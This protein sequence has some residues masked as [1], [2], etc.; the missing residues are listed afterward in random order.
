MSSLKRPLP[1]QL[2]TPEE[3]A[4]V[5][6]RPALESPDQPEQQP[7]SMAPLPPPQ[8]NLEKAL[9]APLRHGV[10]ATI[11]PVLYP[12]YGPHDFFSDLHSYSDEEAVQRKAQI[13]QI[14]HRF[15]PP[16]QPLI[17]NESPANDGGIAVPFIFPP[18]PL[19]RPDFYLNDT[20]LRP[21]PNQTTASVSPP[22]PYA[23]QSA[24]NKRLGMEH[25]TIWPVIPPLPFPPPNYM[26]YPLIAHKAPLTPGEVFEEWIAASEHLP[27]V[28]M[29]VASAAGSMVDIRS[30]S[31]AL[32]FDIEKLDKWMKQRQQESDPEAEEGVKSENESDEDQD[33][34]L[35]YV[36]QVDTT[37]V[38]DIYGKDRENIVVV[39]SDL[40]NEYLNVAHETT[41]GTEVQHPKTHEWSKEDVPE[42]ASDVTPRQ[43]FLKYGKDVVHATGGTK[44]K[45]RKDLLESTNAL[46]RFTERNR[47]QLYFARKLQLLNR[48]RTLQ[49]A[50]VSLD[51]EN[52]SVDDDEFED[53]FRKRKN[54]RDHELLRLKIYHNHEKL[55]A[56][57]LFYQSSNSTYK[58]LNRIV[59]NKLRKLKYFLEHQ[60]SV[61][62]G[63]VSNGSD[64]E[65]LNL[66]SKE[67]ANL[68]NSFVDQDFSSDVKQVFR[69]AT[70]NEDRGLPTVS[71][72][73]DV[74]VS[75]FNKVYTNRE[76][77][78]SVN[79][80]MPLATEE[81]FKLVTGDAPSKLNTK[82][83][84][85]KGKVARH[86]IFQSPLYERLTSGSDSNASDS[87]A[88]TTK[89]RPG[90]RAAPKPMLG[91]EPSKE[92]SE[93]ALVAKIMKQFVGPAAANPDE[94]TEDLDLMKVDTRW[95][96]R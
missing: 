33:D 9:D 78:P 88:S 18:V 29:V 25:Q 79:D 4:R 34:Y 76:H 1:E 35:A 51:D 65:I 14:M 37:D 39:N 11:M 44:D 83:Q 70:M 20:L 96:V 46:N 27:R 43:N 8:V 21:V 80:Y 72:P 32:G 75:S 28:D 61:F 7:K 56:A 68:M 22:T 69:N 12:P 50:R 30:Q 94:L 60:Q 62:A 45:R 86:Q 55:K 52:M 95:P 90:R 74:N 81:E 59:I 24:D 82:D 6:K 42:G 16:A 92:R 66:R 67:S 3:L 17:P 40:R 19:L 15:P 23:P 13:N 5:F 2:P 89:R 47:R 48:L 64:P 93:A 84:A 49:N 38:F 57:L 36:N 26:P 41:E 85:L 54:E 71:N 91:E 63:I 10:P 53:Y 31:E 58:G 87:T 77:S 73:P